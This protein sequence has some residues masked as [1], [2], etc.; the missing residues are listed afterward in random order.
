MAIKA[1]ETIY[2]GY[3]FRSRLEARWAVL[4]HHLGIPY[5]YEQEGFD[6][7]GIRYLPDFYLSEIPHWVEI[8]GEFPGEKEHLAAAS[9]AW[10]TDT[11]VTICHGPIEVPHKATI[12]YL[13]FLM[14]L[15]TSP[16]DVCFDLEHYHPGGVGFA[17]N[18]DLSVQ[19]VQ[20]LL[21]LRENN[22]LFVRTGERGA[23][24]DSNTKR[25]F[26]SLPK[27]LQDQAN[28]LIPRLCARLGDGMWVPYGHLRGS[29]LM[30]CLSCHRFCFAHSK[31][32]EV[33]RG[34][35]YA[36]TPA[37]IAAYTSA[38]QARFE[39]GETP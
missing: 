32:C 16:P 18:E 31:T 2:D 37:L 22:I 12:E 19:E 26:P 39:H 11:L 4:F 5:C 14:F 23:Y 29:M 34:R 3:K 33:C 15:T 20:T 9:L 8:K 36:A 7:H 6:L 17:K 24:I 10:A 30:E 21:T 1:I 35:R 38:R 28:L 13:N 27:A 25:V